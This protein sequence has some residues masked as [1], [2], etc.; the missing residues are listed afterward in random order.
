MSLSIPNI[1]Y[2]NEGSTAAQYQ[3]SAVCQGGEILLNPANS[4]GA[5]QTVLGLMDKGII[6]VDGMTRDQVFKEVNGAL[7]EAKAKG[8]T[9]VVLSDYLDYTVGDQNALSR[10]VATAPPEM[11]DPF[12]EVPSKKA[13]VIDQSGNILLNPDKPIAAREL[14]M[15]LVN[16]GTI[17]VQGMS[18]DEVFSDVM[19]A[20]NEAKA[21]GQTSV[22]LSDYVD[23]TVKDP[24]AL[25]QRVGAEAPDQADP[26]LDRTNNSYL[27][28]RIDSL[29]GRMIPRNIG[30]LH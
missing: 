9:S 7:N 25:A 3:K 23:Y 16:K 17:T 6:K 22:V 15:G 14:V 28:D 10:R 2:G 18:K 30:D 27:K 19:G 26:F 4:A 5:R 11:D 21:K 29:V 8:Q 13:G 1:N 24:K 20:F 12:L